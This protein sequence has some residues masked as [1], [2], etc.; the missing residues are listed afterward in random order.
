MFIM[1]IGKFYGDFDFWMML[2]VNIL[3][4]VWFIILCLF[5]GVW[6]GFIFIG[7]WFLVLIFICMVLVC[8]R[9]VFD[10]VNRFWCCEINF[11]ICWWCLGGMFS[12]V[13]MFWRLL[14]FFVLVVGLMYI[15]LMVLILLMM[16]LC[17]ILKILLVL[18]ISNIGILYDCFVFVIVFLIIRFGLLFRKYLLIVLIL[19][20]LFIK[21]EW[22]LCFV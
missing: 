7:G 1:M 20:V 21:F 22:F 8:F 17:F 14:F 9:F 13:V 16:L 12:F 2:V 5:K 18:L 11:F 6:Y 15:L 19:I 10:I 3:F 4:M